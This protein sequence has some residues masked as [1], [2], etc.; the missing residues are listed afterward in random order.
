MTTTALRIGRNRPA[1]DLLEAVMNEL[2][3]TP[4]ITT[5]DLNQIRNALRHLDG[6]PL[7]FLARAMRR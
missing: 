7:E 1:P 3:Q 2:A 6:R 4:D 5:R